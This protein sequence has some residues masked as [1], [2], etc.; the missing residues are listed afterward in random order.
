MQFGLRLRALREQAGLT[1][2]QLADSSKIHRV[3]IARAETGTREIGLTSVLALADALA[4][5][6]GELLNG[7][8]PINQTDDVADS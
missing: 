7:L 4:V 6:P 3:T 8:V 2:Q 5:E 1:Q